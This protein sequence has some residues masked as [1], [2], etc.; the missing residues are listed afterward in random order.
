MFL[1]FRASRTMARSMCSVQTSPHCC[2]SRL[3]WFFDDAPSP[4]AY[5]QKKSHARLF[6]A[7][8]GPV[9]MRMGTAHVRPHSAA[10]VDALIASMLDFPALDGSCE[11]L[12]GG[13]DGRFSQIPVT[14]RVGACDFSLE[15]LLTGMD[16]AHQV[17]LACEV[18]Q[19]GEGET[20]ELVAPNSIRL[21]GRR[22]VALGFDGG[23]FQAFRQAFAVEMKNANRDPP[24]SRFH[25]FRDAQLE[26]PALFLSS[27]QIVN[28]RD[29]SRSAFSCGPWDDEYGAARRQAEGGGRS[30]RWPG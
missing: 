27:E 6:A 18:K 14:L 25:E 28:R 10:C 23:G 9:Q 20:G 15:W 29:I 30:L 4:N 16:D 17:G 24:L 7:L 11:G 8:P 12:A 3:V 19:K 21:A 5:R 13:L 22:A 1:P 2:H 26:T